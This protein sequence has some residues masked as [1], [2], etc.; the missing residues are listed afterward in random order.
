M[1]A[2]RKRRGHSN[3]ARAGGRGAPRR[4]RGRVSRF[5]RRFRESSQTRHRLVS[6]PRFCDTRWHETIRPPRPIGRASFRTNSSSPKPAG[7]ERV[8]SLP[9]ALR[10]HGMQS[11]RRG[12]VRT[13]PRG[14]AARGT[15]PL[16]H[17]GIFRL[18]LRSVSCRIT[19][20]HA[21][22]IDAMR[23]ERSV[24][25]KLKAT[26]SS[27]GRGSG[28]LRSVFPTVSQDVQESWRAANGHCTADR[29]SGRWS[30]LGG[31]QSGSKKGIL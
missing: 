19:P 14:S 30:V 29:S 5:G 8:R 13:P 20:R 22:C 25:L 17:T 31:W 1:A 21:N 27:S 23:K 16:C 11:E 9:Q 26:K 10:P 18:R 15:V 28:S 4:A 6:A 12:G 24:D 2:A 3:P 7:M